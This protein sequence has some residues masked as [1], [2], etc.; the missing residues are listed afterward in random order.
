MNASP[1]ASIIDPVDRE[2]VNVPR[3]ISRFALEQRSRLFDEDH[4]GVRRLMWAILKDTLRCY[5]NHF[6]S[7]SVQ[8]QRVFREAN[9]WIHSDDLTWVF[10]F[11]SICAVLGIDGD[12]LRSELARWG[13]LHRRVETILVE[14]TLRE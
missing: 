14:A 12:R 10:S 4:D 8:S 7:S 5:Q 11:E 9:R 2:A 13:R 3:R 1:A 6:D